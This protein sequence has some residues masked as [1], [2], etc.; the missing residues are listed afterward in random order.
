MSL[1]HTDPQGAVS[2]VPLGNVQLTAP[3]ERLNGMGKAGALPQAKQS[4]RSVSLCREQQTGL[5]R[6]EA[7]ASNEYEFRCHA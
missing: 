2:E 5:D 4:L 7:R 3:P 1:A 6:R